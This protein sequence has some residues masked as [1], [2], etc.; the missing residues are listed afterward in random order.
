MT[1]DYDRDS[2]ESFF[3]RK[4]VVYDSDPDSGN[5]E[6]SYIGKKL[7]YT[8]LLRETDQV[9]S[10]SADPDAPF[11]ANSFLELNVPCDSITVCVDGYYPEQTG[12]E[13]WYGDRAH[14]PN[15]TMILLKR[16]DSDLKI[17]PGCTWPRR[18]PLHKICWDGVDSDPYT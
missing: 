12:L 4:L 15:Q 5:F 7:K 10:I 16:P 17:W 18:H 9:V 3:D 1:I 6:L 11:G 8:F 13:F 14:K 2:V